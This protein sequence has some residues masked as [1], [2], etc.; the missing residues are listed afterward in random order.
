MVLKP[1]SEI[2]FPFQRSLSVVTTD[3]PKTEVITVLSL[4]LPPCPVPICH[5]RL[6][7]FTCLLTSL[8][9]GTR[10]VSSYM[11]NT[12]ASDECYE[13]GT[14]PLLAHQ[15]IEDKVRNIESFPLNFPCSPANV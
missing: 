3:P 2:L 11:V 7:E 6:E 8:G 5:C 15:L 12:D 1:S 4:S 10:A 9:S 13:M 14:L